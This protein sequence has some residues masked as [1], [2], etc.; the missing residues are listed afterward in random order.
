MRT[1]E[2][3]MRGVVIELG[4]CRPR[5]NVVAGFATSAGRD[6]EIMRISMACRTRRIAEHIPHGPG[7]RVFCMAIRTCNRRM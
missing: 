1:G 3:E 7:R 6:A 4:Y 2:R 5:T